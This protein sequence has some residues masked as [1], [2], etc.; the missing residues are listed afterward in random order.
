MEKHLPG[1]RQQLIGSWKMIDWKVFREDVTLDP[2]LGPAST[3]AVVSSST[4][5]TGR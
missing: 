1:I 2:P 4:A 3:N 5:R